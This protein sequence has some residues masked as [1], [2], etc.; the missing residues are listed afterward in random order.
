MAPGSSPGPQSSILGRDSGDPGHH[1]EAQSPSAPHGSLGRAGQHPRVD[2]AR[3]GR[4]Q[5]L[6]PNCP[7][8]SLFLLID[9]QLTLGAQRGPVLPGSWSQF[10]DLAGV[11]QAGAFPLPLLPLREGQCSRE[12]TPSPLRY[13]EASPIVAALPPW[14]PRLGEAERLP[15]VPQL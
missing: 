15:T 3:G 12:A 1:G 14:R 11:A 5:V 4:C 6:F 10:S 7:G 8:W 9:S 2:K 13:C